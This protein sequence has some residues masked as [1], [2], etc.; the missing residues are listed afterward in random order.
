MKRLSVV[1]PGYNTPDR[2]W[3]RCVRS[4]LNAISSDDEVICVDDGSETHPAALAELA[5]EDKRVRII[6]LE[7]NAGLPTARNAGLD[8]AEGKY[9]TFVDSDD[10]VRPKTYAMT[11]ASM[12]I[13]NADV[14]VFGV[15]GIY[16]NDGFMVHDIPEDKYYGELAPEDVGYLVK[17][18]LFYYSWNKVLRKSFLDANGFKFDPKGVPCEDAI[19]NVALVVKKAK[20]VTVAYEGYIYYRY[21]GSL[22][23]TYKPTYVEGTCACTKAWKDY[24]DSTPGAYEG[25][26]KFGLGWYDERSEDDIVRGQWTNIWR[27]KSPFGMKERWRYAKEHADVLGRATAWVFVKKAVAMWLRAHCYWKPVRVWHEKRFLKEIGAKMVPIRRFVSVMNIPS[28]YRLPLFEELDKQLKERGIIYHVDFM[29]RGHNDR[30]KSWLNPR[31][32]VSH[33]YWLDIGI[34]QHHFNLGLVLSLIVNPPYYLDLGSPYD[35]FTCILLALFCRSKVKIMALEG[36]TKTPGR[37]GGFVGWFKRLI[38]KRATFLP[39][40]GSDGRKFIGMHQQRTKIKLGQTP[41]IPNI[42]DQSQFHPRQYWPK[43]QIRATRERLGI[44]FDS[45]LCIIPAR[46]VEVKGLVPLIRVLDA[47]MIQGWKIVIIGEGPLKTKIEAEIANGNLNSHIKVVDFVR[48]EDMPLIYAASDMLLLPSIYDPNPLSVVE[49]L[50][51]GLPI[52]LSCMAGNVEEGVTEGRNG[53]I[54][55]VSDAELYRQKLVEV[56]SIP[57]ERLMEMGKCSLEEN[58]KFWDATPAIRKYLDVVV[59]GQND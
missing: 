10:E 27:R 50:F 35:T 7:N 59:G 2:W 31:L 34:G 13:H 49:A 43:R 23:S 33:E 55:P 36:N 11:L 47:Q 39:V 6:R 37:L 29:A 54:L 56:F 58:S 14:G 19:F 40:P 1:V 16:V 12:D 24:K 48:Y 52:A 18:R 32:D 30:P 53:W 44:D 51:S 9:V 17:R 3:R 38:I 26:E 21:D 28:P 45:K 57:L 8:A 5:Q 41:F 15:N 42:I 22:L 25:L 46:L 20:W 4:I